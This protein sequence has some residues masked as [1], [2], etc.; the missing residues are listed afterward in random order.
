MGANHEA[1]PVDSALAALPA[2]PARAGPGR[3]GQ[4]RQ[5]GGARAPPRRHAA[6]RCRGAQ[7]RGVP[8][9]GVENDWRYLSGGDVTIVSDSDLLIQ[10]IQKIMFTI[11]YSNPFHSGYGT[12]IVDQIGQKLTMGGL[13]QNRIVAEVNATFTKWQKIKKQQEEVVGQLVTDEE[14]PYRL[15]SV[16]LDQSQTDPTVVFVNVE[17]MS[18]STKPILITR[19][20]R[21]PMPEDLLGS[22]QQSSIIR[23]LQSNTLVG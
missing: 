21:V 3:A 1:R 17:I 9:R 14:F 12:T 6:D 7:L 13:I 18:R 15:Q 5:R 8:G 23:N 19:G 16:T 20:F 10:E 11:R 22:T 4:V 2:V